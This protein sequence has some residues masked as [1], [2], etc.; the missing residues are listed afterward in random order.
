MVVLGLLGGFSPSAFK[1]KIP[2]Q[3]LLRLVTTDATWLR[4]TTGTFG[5]GR[6]VIGFA[7]Q[8]AV[9]HQVELVTSVQLPAADETLEALEVIDVLLGSA[10]HL[11][12]SNALLATSALGTESP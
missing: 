7:D 8:F 2:S 12:R 5:F 1:D 6:L 11:R 10:D 4:R 9:L 3:A